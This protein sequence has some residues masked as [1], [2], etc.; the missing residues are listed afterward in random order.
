MTDISPGVAFV[1][2]VPCRVV[3]TRPSQGFSGA[4]G[5]PIMAANAIRTFDIDSGPCTG[6]PAGVDAYSLNF[7]VTET[8]GAPG[9]IR[10]FPT[11]AGVSVTSVLNWNFVGNG[12]IANAIIVP[13]GT[14]GA[15]DVQVAGFDTHLVID[16]N[17]YF[18]DS[19]NPGV[20][21][22]AVGNVPG[23]PSPGS[24]VVFA[25]NTNTVNTYSNGGAFFSESCHTGSAGVVGE[26]LSS[27]APG[28]GPVFGVWGISENDFDGSTG[29]YGLQSAPSGI[30]FGVVGATNSSTND[31]AGVWGYAGGL[32]PGRT[33]GVSGESN[34][35]VNGAAGVLGIDVNGMTVSAAGPGGTIGVRGDSRFG[36]GVLGLSEDHDAA[37]RAVSGQL[38]N[39]SNGEPIATG[40]LGYDAGMD[41]YGVFAAGDYGGTG[42]KYFVEPHPQD[43]SKVIRYVALEGPEAGTYFR[44]KGKFQNG[45]ATIDVPEDFR[46]VTDADS[47]SVVATPIGDMAVIA[48]SRVGLNRIVLRSSRNV[49]F[50]YLVNGVRETHKGLEPIVEG[51]EYVPPSADAKMPSYLTEGQKRML[52]A[53]GTYDADGTV[54]LETARRLGW[55]RIWEKRA[56]PRP[57]PAAE[58]PAVAL[59]TRN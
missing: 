4:Y 39:F 37:Q 19:Y 36:T 45:V 8:A 44:G 50:F 14:N 32:A 24:G 53:N 48:V 51:W 11:G 3:D 6:I 16:I 27:G 28:C 17:G 35:V 47:L 1:A 55:D 12:A 54:N 38:V 9:D 52:I 10:A 43:A 59:P 21:F 56:R 46:L 42:A 30:V 13:A 31:S 26:T 18:T 33:Y 7:A 2:M 29:V 23:G 15:I 49:E 41:N 20:P 34:S 57:E 58:L 40:H 25:R 22:R 5:P